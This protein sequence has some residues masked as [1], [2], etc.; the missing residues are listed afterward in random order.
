MKIGF[1]AKRAVQ[2]NTGLGNYSRYVLEALQE[3]YPY[4]EYILYAPKERHNPRLDAVLVRDNAKLRLPSSNIWK[5]L[6][7]LWRIWGITDDLISDGVHLFHGLSNEL[8]LNIKKQGRVKTVVTVHDL[9]FRRLPYCYPF[10]DRA[11]YDYKFKRA[12]CNADLIIAVSECTKRDIVKEYGISPDKIEVIYQGCDS[13]F[14]VPVSDAKKNEVRA[15]YALPSRFVISVGTIEKRKNTLLAVKAL[16]YLPEDT[17]LVLVGRETAYAKEIYSFINSEGIK[18]R[19]HLIHNLPFADLPAIYQCAD[20]FVYPSRYEGFG[21]PI[22]E[23][24]NSRIPVIAATG[25]CLEEAGGPDSIYVNPDDAEA[26][27]RAI[28]EVMEPS[29]REQMIEKGLLWAAQ[30]SKG[31]L[32]HRVMECYERLIER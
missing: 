15:R 21:I 5:R 28:A 12:C 30:F 22:L 16:K 31:Q 32:A 1:D 26:M 3:H 13:A 23:A 10:I 2:N 29:L 25:S 4:D 27:A 11:I 20:V 14:A 9:I 7:S 24:L 6:S 18:K 8:P 17:H 19:V